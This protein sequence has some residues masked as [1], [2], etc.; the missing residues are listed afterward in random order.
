VSGIIA[1]PVEGVLCRT[2]FPSRFKFEVCEDFNNADG[3][4]PDAVLNFS[5]DVRTST[6]DTQ[7]HLVDLTISLNRADGQTVPYEIDLVMR[8]FFRVASEVPE[9]LRVGFLVNGAPSVL[10]SAARE[11]IQTMTARCPNG[12]FILSMTRFKIPDGGDGEPSKRVKMV[13]KKK[14]TTAK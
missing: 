10:Y 1:T 2:I 11:F 12:P 8:G 13:R 3:D 14:E 7:E 9:P 4:L 6:D 5:V